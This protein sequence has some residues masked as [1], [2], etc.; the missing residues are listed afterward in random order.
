MSIKIAQV[1]KKFGNFQALDNINLNVE[2]GTLVALLG[3]SGSG[4][5]TLLR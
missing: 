3:P 2:P 4:K 1:S 5:S